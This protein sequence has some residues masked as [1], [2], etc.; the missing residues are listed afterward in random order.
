MLISFTSY[1]PSQLPSQ[2][3][4][5]ASAAILDIADRGDALFMT[6]Y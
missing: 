1:L 2:F 6:L 4:K 3:P 5:G